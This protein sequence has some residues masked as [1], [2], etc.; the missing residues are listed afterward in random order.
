MTAHGDSSML[1][2]R[3]ADH[4][5]DINPNDEQ[6]NDNNN[7][8]TKGIVNNSTHNNDNDIDNS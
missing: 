2:G 1:N 5:W 3:E 4:G 6:N 7:N 8:N